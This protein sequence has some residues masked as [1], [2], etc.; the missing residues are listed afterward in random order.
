MKFPLLLS[1]LDV[2]YNEK[3]AD[4]LEEIVLKKDLYFANLSTPF[5]GTEI[6][7]YII[8]PIDSHPNGAAHRIFA[9]VLYEFLLRD[10]NRQLLSVRK[11]E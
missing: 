7:D 5:E 9:D 8:Y 6:D 11:E 1:I 2:F 4:K 10:E 3:F